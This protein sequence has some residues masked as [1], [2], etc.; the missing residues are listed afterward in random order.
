MQGSSPGG[1]MG[2]RVLES[3]R[4]EGLGM[5]DEPSERRLCDELLLPMLEDFLFIRSKIYFGK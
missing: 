5:Y 4:R 2:R 1:G 3:R